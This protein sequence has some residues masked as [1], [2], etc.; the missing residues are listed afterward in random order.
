MWLDVAQLLAATFALTVGCLVAL[1][2]ICLFTRDP[3]PMDSYWAFG[4]VLIAA[5]SFMAFTGPPTERKVW[6]LGLTAAWGLRLGLYL[7][8]RSIRHGPDPRYARMM[9]KAQQN[10]G[11]SYGRASL[12][13]VFLKQAP[14]LWLTALPVQLG[15]L[16]DGTNGQIGPLGYAGACLCIFG[17]LFETIGDWQLV[18]FKADPANAG[19]IMDRGLWRYTRHPNYFGDA[20]AW[21]GLYLLASETI[22]GRLSLIGPLF[23]TYTLVVWSGAGLLERLMIRKKPHYAHYIATTSGFIPWFPKKARHGE[24]GRSADPQN[25]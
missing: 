9:Q 1:W 10:R 22:V 15:Q 24:P 21:W 2:V 12:W 19:K 13:L 7:L 25:E 3:S 4:M 17:I 18:R 20:C 16:P 23:L 8:W 11:W 5:L 6:L 14:L